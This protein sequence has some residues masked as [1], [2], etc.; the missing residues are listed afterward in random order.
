MP[1]KDLHAARS[2]ACLT[3]IVLTLYLYWPCDSTTAAEKNRAQ[4]DLTP[5]ITQGDM[6]RVKLLFELDGKLTLKSGTAGPVQTPVKVKAQLAYDE[7]TIDA[8]AAPATTWSPSAVRYY[9]TARASI[10]FPEGACNRHFATIGESSPSRQSLP[11]MSLSFPR[12][13]HSIA[14]NLT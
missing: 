12:W 5:H 4:V 2:L 10:T 9:D 1:A 11:T 13:D 7:K 6:Q 8:P 14:M 3:V